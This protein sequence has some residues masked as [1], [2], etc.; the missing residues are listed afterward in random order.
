MYIVNMR[1]ED[2]SFLQLKFRDMK[3]MLKS[4]QKYTFVKAESSAILILLQYHC[5]STGGMGWVVGLQWIF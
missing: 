4:N 2:Y 3:S 1:N 5:M